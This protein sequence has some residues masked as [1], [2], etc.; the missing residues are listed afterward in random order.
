MKTVHCSAMKAAALLLLLSVIANISPAA[1]ANSNFVSNPYLPYPPS[2]PK[3]PGS[4]AT[5][6]ADTG[7]VKFFEG[8]VALPDQQTF[9]QVDFELRAYRS[10]CSET[11]RSL[12]W[13]EFRI[14]E[15][16][17]SKDIQVM[18]PILV[19]D[20]ESDFG[21]RSS[22]LA[23]AS[24]PG[25]WGEGGAVESERI[26][27]VTRPHGDPDGNDEEVLDAWDRSWWFLL[28]NQSPLV[29]EGYNI[30]YLMSAAAYNSNFSLRLRYPPNHHI[31]Q[32]E[33]PSTAGM[34]LVAG[35]DFS[36]TGRLSGNWVIEGANDQG[37]M[38]AISSLIPKPEAASHGFSNAMLLFFSQY[39]FD[40]TGKMLWLTGAVEFSPG[41][42]QVTFPI[43]EVNHGEFRGHQPAQRR[44]V[45]HITLTA[46]HCND[47]TMEYDF[48]SLGLGTGTERLQRLI[49]L[50]TAGYDC[51]DYDARVE[52]NR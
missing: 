34:G 24:N 8:V 5:A 33:V 7:A 48:S 46:N 10:P 51:R 21:I 37:F 36:F 38:L 19:A 25:S 43:D 44:T 13:L 16:D 3:M 11:G 23:P 4:S 15:E 14:S 30:P 47:I 28:D 31:L 35:E 41:V 1:L 26:M 45:G 17:A 50:E 6:L 29:D 42:R 40:P 18:L 9:E 32:I 52:A 12:L 49:S 20:Y 2:C 39:T 27:L 22:L